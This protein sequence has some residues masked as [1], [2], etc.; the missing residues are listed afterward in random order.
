MKVS[1][2]FI[3]SAHENEI[4]EISTIDWSV[5]ETEKQ[6]IKNAIHFSNAKVKVEINFFKNKQIN[7]LGFE[8]PDVY[9]QSDSFEKFGYLILF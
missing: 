3:Y 6:Q 9:L 5:I 1:T 4:F 2:A 7:V 8:M